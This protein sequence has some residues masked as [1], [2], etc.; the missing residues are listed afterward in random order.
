MLVDLHMHSAFSDG[1]DSPAELIRAVKKAGI[2][3]FALT[4]HD[5]F[6][7]VAE[8][9]QLLGEMPGAPEFHRGIEFSCITPSGKVHILGYEF[10]PKSEAMAAAVAEGRR[11]RKIKFG[12]RLDHLEK[13]H[14]IRFSDE[15]MAYLNAQR[16]VGKP[17]IASILVKRGLAPDITSAIREFIDDHGGKDSTDARIPAEMAVSAIL[18]AGGIPV[19]AH[20]LG[21]EGERHL[22]PD[23]FDACL[24]ELMADGIRGLECFYSRYSA[25]EES[26]LTGRAEENHLFKSGG[27]DYHGKNKTILPGTL[28]ADNVTISLN[29]ITILSQFH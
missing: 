23:E 1:S 22:S 6:D 17:H 11:L 25:D 15:E 18:E 14:H 3:I 24:T 28:R 21:G 27:S 4:D 7:G 19:W 29:N 13:W 20:P 26:F 8:T 12:K 9:E 16:S 10:D 2:G 5:T